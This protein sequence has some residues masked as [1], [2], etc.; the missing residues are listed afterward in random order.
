MSGQ[1][2]NVIQV[3]TF[4]SKID[5]LSSRFE[6]FHKSATCQALLHHFSMSK[7]KSGQSYYIAWSELLHRP[8]DASE[9]LQ[10]GVG[11]RDVFG[12]VRGAAG[13]VTFFARQTVEIEAFLSSP[14]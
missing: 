11:I 3:V 10:F 13:L 7:R 8:L 9:N 4:G 5:H 12:N 6:R 1:F 2:E 14:T